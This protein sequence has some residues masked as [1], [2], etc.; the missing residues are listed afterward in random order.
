[1]LMSKG[2]KIKTISFE[3]DNET[4]GMKFTGSYELISSNDIVLAKQG[5]NGYNDL[6][7]SESLETKDLINKLIAGLSSDLNK[8]LGM[9]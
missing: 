1:M 6:K 9:E 3:R 2:A 7:L 5:F 4:G 8:T